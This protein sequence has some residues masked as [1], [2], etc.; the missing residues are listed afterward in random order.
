MQYNNIYF[1]RCLPTD[2]VGQILTALQVEDHTITLT[3]GG[4]TFILEDPNDC[5]EKRYFHTDDEVAP[6]LQT[7]IISIEVAKAPSLED[8]DGGRHE[9]CFLRIGTTVG[10][11]V[12]SAHN[13]HNGY[14]GGFNLCVHP[15]EATQ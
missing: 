13:I 15:V 8:A 4:R 10:V 2:L 1:S 3:A 5:C 6:H 11:F 12:V 7:H 14:Y 9:V